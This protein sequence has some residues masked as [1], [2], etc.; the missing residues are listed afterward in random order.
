VGNTYVTRNMPA[1]AV[2]GIGRAAAA[3]RPE[4]SRWT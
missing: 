3:V 2:I 4:V 1:A